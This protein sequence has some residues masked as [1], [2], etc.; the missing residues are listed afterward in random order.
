MIGFLSIDYSSPLLPEVYFI[1]PWLM[2]E[3]C[4]P[5]IIHNTNKALD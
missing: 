5:I 1:N 2:G 3:K 4:R